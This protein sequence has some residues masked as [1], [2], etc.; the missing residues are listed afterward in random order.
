VYGIHEVLCVLYN[1]LHHFVNP[2]YVIVI[3]IFIT[4]YYN[5]LFIS[6]F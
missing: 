5:L 2:N 6:S 3:I 4:A 1:K